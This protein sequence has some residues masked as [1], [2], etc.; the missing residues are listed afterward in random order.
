MKKILAAIDG[1]DQAWKALNLATDMAK[2]HEAEL[3]ILHV[4]P[5]E[6]IPEAMRQFAKV[7]HVPLEEERARYHYAKALGDGLNAAG[8]SLRSKQR[9]YQGLGTDRRRQARR[10]DLGDREER[11]CRHDRLG[12]SRSRLRLGHVARQ[13]L[14]QGSQSGRCHLC[15]RQIGEDS[16]CRQSTMRRHEQLLGPD[17]ISAQPLNIGATFGAAKAT[18]AFAA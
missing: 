16:P 10:R 7:E 13:R 11:S 1:S 3:V 12:K 17:E 8:R 9:A 14:A 5:Y 4:V 6:D 2:L 18:H 15:C